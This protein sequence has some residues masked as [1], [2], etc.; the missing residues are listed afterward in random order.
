[1]Q[2]SG[3]DLEFLARFSKAPEG[4]AFLT[5][6]QAKLAERDAKLRIS[7]GEEVFRTQGRALELAELIDE[8]N[9]A[10]LKLNRSL[11]ARTSAPRQIA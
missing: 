3:Q 8:V 10:Q 1:M 2:L 9:T 11:S 6:L 7:V 4:R 5:L